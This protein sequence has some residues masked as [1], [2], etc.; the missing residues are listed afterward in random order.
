M[1]CRKKSPA[2]RRIQNR[3]TPVKH[4]GDMGIGSMLVMILTLMMA[5]ILIMAYASWHGRLAAQ[6]SIYLTIGT[7]LKSIES[8]GCLTEEQK[9]QLVN[10]L[11]RYGM[12]NINLEGTTLAHVPYGSKVTLRV[13]GRVHLSE[14]P[15]LVIEDN[16]IRFNQDSYVEV[17]ILRSGISFS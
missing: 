3:R 17:D 16:D 6:D 11:E 14:V 13:R 4:Q 5:L 15:D 7:Y 10:E 2:D 9:E 12:E 1:P 8:S